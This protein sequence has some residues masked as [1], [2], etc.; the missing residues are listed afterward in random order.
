MIG[1][2]LS[3]YQTKRFQLSRLHLSFS[4]ARV[5]LFFFTFSVNRGLEA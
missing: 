4:L 3:S 2:K 5:I 1:K